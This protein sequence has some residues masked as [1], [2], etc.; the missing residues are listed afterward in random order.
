MTVIKLKQHKKRYLETAEKIQQIQKDWNLSNVE[1]AHI[2]GIS[3]SAVSMMKNGGRPPTIEQTMKLKDKLRV[4]PGWILGEDPQPYL[5]GN[6][7]FIKLAN[8]TSTSPE[9]AWKELKAYIREMH[10]SPALLLPDILAAVGLEQF[11]VF[12]TH[13]ARFKKA[14]R[15]Y[16]IYGIDGLSPRDREHIAAFAS[17]RSRIRQILGIA[18]SFNWQQFLAGQ[19]RHNPY[20][21]FSFAYEELTNLMELEILAKTRNFPNRPVICLACDKVS[22]SEEVGD[23]K[24]PYCGEIVL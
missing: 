2:M 19:I 3:D 21:P 8:I 23:G 12:F 7:K 5:R 9:Q 1:M 20:E 18:P 24:C 14:V 15:A 17:D 11:N 10:N 16:V 13:L 4:N 6:Y 22:L